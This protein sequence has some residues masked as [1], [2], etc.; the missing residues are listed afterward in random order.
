MPIHPF[1][2]L[3]VRNTRLNPKRPLAFCLHDWLAYAMDFRRLDPAVAAEP[4]ASPA[5]GFHQVFF[6][7][8]AFQ[9]PL[10]EL[11]NSDGPG[12]CVQG[13]NM[14]RLATDVMFV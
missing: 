7:R 6:H 9:T 1:H 11:D 3:S 8:K 13:V 5:P 4:Q 14:N 10:G 12:Q 2:Y